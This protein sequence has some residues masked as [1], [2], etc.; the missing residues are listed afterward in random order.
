VN[1]SLSSRCCC[2]RPALLLG[3]GGLIGAADV[4]IWPIW[5]AAA[6]G[7]LQQTNRAIWPLSRR[8][9]L[10]P[11]GKVSFTKCVDRFFSPLRSIMPF[12]AGICAMRRVPF[13]IANIGSAVIWATGVLTPGFVAI[14]WLL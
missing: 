12:V 13:Q 4:A 11:R 6:L 8:P 10:L 14:E 5:W 1:R 3:A 7:V 2:R 9:D